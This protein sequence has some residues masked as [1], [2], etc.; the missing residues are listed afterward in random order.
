M[1][2]CE[3]FLGR[4]AFRRQWSLARPGLDEICLLEI[5]QASEQFV[6]T[7]LI[8]NLD[9][10]KISSISP[11]ITSYSNSPGTPTLEDVASLQIW[12]HDHGPLEVFKNGAKTG[13][14]SGWLFELEEIFEGQGQ[15]SIHLRGNPGRPRD[16]GSF[17][18]NSG[19]LS[20]SSGPLSENSGSFSENS[21][22]ISDNSGSLS[23]NSAASIFYDNTPIWILLVK[24][25]SP[26][27]PFAE[28][29]DSGSLVFARV[30]GC[31]VPLGIHYGSKG[32]VSRAY[33]LHTWWEEMENLDPHNETDF[34][35][36]NPLQCLSLTEE[37]GTP[38]RECV[39]QT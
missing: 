23:E 36:C 9:C 26:E 38:D 31:I 33:L 8:K 15:P 1:I 19:S 21:G 11:E 22:S 39:Q 12:L 24:W 37:Q 16:S 25:L 28:S 29:G 17:S 10:N 34:Y 14:T 5:P 18:D 30:D 2:G 35:F 6:L 13:E 3:R 27:V 20:E 4:P 32:D 7:C